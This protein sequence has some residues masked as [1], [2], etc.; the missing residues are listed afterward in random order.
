MPVLWLEEPGARD[1]CR[2]GAKAARLSRLAGRFLVPAGFCLPVELFRRPVELARHAAAA[3]EEMARRRDRPGLRVAVRSSGLLE[4]G[5]A[6]SFAGQYTSVLNL[7]GAEQVLAAVEKVAASACGER[8]RAYRRHRSG[9]AGS[10]A[11]EIAVL[12]QEMVAA[13][14]SGVAFTADPVTGRRDAVVIEACWGL[15]NALVEGWVQPDRYLVRKADLEIEEER[16]GDKQWMAVLE[17][18]EQTGVRRMRVPAFLRTRPALS[19]G[20][21]QSVARLAREIEEE[22]GAPADVE[23]AL[24][25]DLV[26]V[27]QCRPVTALPPT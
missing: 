14:V 26:Y 11:P 8:V 17:T 2:V 20:Q 22:L 13:D 15:G 12:V 1:A 10:S 3:Y 6:A 5:G 18:A 16:P 21:V 9:S 4:D 7:A 27:L 19:P 23:L 25:G 24:R